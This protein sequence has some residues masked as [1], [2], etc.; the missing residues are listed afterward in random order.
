MLG[1]PQAALV[2]AALCGLVNGLATA[3]L[4]LAAPGRM[5]LAVG[6]QVHLFDFAHFLALGLAL[7]LL[8][9]L[10]AR[11]GPARPLWGRLAMLVVAVPCAWPFLDEDLAGPSERLTALLPNALDPA[12]YGLLVAAVALPVPIAGA[13]GAALSRWRPWL[14]LLPLLGGGALVVANHFVLK[15]DYP[16]AHLT[17]ATAAVVVLAGGLVG[18]PLPKADARRLHLG[19]FGVALAGALAGLLVRPSNQGLV[20]LDAVDGSP[21]VTFLAR[22]HGDDDAGTA[23][24]PKTPWFKSRKGLPSKAAST[25]PLIPPDAVVL[26]FSADSVRADL[27]EDNAPELARFPEIKRLR[28]E[29]VW[30]RTARAPGAQT[31]YTLSAV[32]AGTY[33]SQQFWTLKKAENVASLWPWE[34]RTPRFP[35]LLAKKGVVTAN[36][37]QAEWGQSA[38]GLV[39]GFTEDRWIRPKPGAKWATGQMVTDALVARIKRHSTGPLFLYTHNLDPHAPFDLGKKTGT[40]REKWLSEVELVDKQ[41]GQL[42]AAIAEAGLEARTTIVFAADHGEGWGEH[43]TSFH[44]QNL[45]DEQ[46]RVPLMIRVPGVAARRVDTPVSLIDLGPTFLDLYGVPTPAHFMGESLVP[47][48]RGQTPKATRPI[49]AEGRLK[50]SMILP[51][52]PYKVVRDQRSGSTEIYDLSKD[53]LELDNLYDDLGPAGREK[54]A[55][56]KAFFETH[57]IRKKG[58]KIPYRR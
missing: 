40:S 9:G 6:L 44:G 51:G 56:L 30:F 12:A 35:A 20:A 5:P 53:P 49:V 23:A 39:R 52:D 24:V 54:L 34:D 31:V 13:V 38:Y 41:L 27:F 37:C 17:V 19:L 15:A 3:A 25:P 43:G 22:L 47:F 57:K 33:F 4:R 28:D 48:L 16:G 36:F 55:V 7:A 8:T 18:L 46:V 1:W 50:Q 14:R 58:Y 2:S 26:Y 10:W 11:F 42:R 45:Y 29:S 21:L 32:F